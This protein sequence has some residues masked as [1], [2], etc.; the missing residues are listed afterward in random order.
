MSKSKVQQILDEYQARKEAAEA[1]SQRILDNEKKIQKLKLDQEEAANRSDREGFRSLK[2]QIEDLEDDQYILKKQ[3]GRPL[4]SL[5]QAK[6][7]W[8]EYESGYEKQLDSLMDAFQKQ[9]KIMYDKLLPI[10]ALQN[11][12]LG[13]REQLAEICGINPVTPVSP[14]NQEPFPAFRMK[15]F[16]EVGDPR[17]QN[18][19]IWQPSAK[20]ALLTG[21]FDDIEKKA[22]YFNDV[23]RMRRYYH[24]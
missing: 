15:F 4:I 14:D 20:W 2:H 13:I 8:K 21:A 24:I 9:K 19:R 5:E 11:E 23:L 1:I 3:Q 17:Y 18:I 16:E 7:A 6:D 10:I 22:N 12:A